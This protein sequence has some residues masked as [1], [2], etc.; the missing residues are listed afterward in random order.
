[1]ACTFVF[2]L[3]WFVLDIAEFCSI[4]ASHLEMVSKLIEL[5]LFYLTL[6]DNDGIV[7]CSKLAVDELAF[8]RAH[9]SD[10]EFFIWEDGDDGTIVVFHFYLV[11]DDIEIFLCILFLNSYTLNFLYVGCCRAIEDRKLWSVDLN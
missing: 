3:Q 6:V 2:P 4:H 9:G 8:E 1:M 5:F 10:A 11:T 7:E